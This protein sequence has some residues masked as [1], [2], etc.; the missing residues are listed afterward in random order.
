MKFWFL[1]FGFW[2]GDCGVGLDVWAPYLYAFTLRRRKRAQMLPVLN[3]VGAVR[4]PGLVQDFEQ[5]CDGG[6][7]LLLLLMRGSGFWVL[8]FGFR[9]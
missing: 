8:G 3:F 2:S 9:V 5:L 7:Q 1:V 4:G 6:M